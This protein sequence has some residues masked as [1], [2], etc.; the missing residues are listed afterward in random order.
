VITPITIILCSLF[1]FSF[2]DY[3]F[4]SCSDFARET[5][6]IIIMIILLVLYYLLLLNYLDTISFCNINV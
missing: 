6:A 5:T 1:P 4:F 2:R 3:L